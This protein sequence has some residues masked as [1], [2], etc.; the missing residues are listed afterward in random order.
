MSATAGSRAKPHRIRGRVIAGHMRV[1][2]AVCLWGSVSLYP[3]GGMAQTTQLGLSVRETLPPEEGTQDLPP[4]G[5]RPEDRAVEAEPLIPP[6]IPARMLA[7]RP[8]RRVVVIDQEWLGDSGPAVQRIGP[9]SM[10][11]RRMAGAQRGVGLAPGKATQGRIGR[12]KNALPTPPPA[13]DTD[14]DVTT[15]TD[16]D[17]DDTL[18]GTVWGLRPWLSHYGVTLDIQE[19][20]ELWGNLTGGVPPAGG[21]GAGTGPAFNGV[22][23]PTLTVDL[24]KLIGLKDGVFNVSALQIHGRSITQDRLFNYNPVSGIE[25]DRSTR[26][27]ELWYEQGFW[28]DKLD[29]KI[30][31]QDLDTE[32]VIST[33]GALYLNANF[34][35]PMGPS[36]NLYAGGPSWPLASPAVRV[37][38]RPATNLTLM[39][40][41][42]DDNPPGNSW[43]SFDAQNGGLGNV[44]DPTS[45]NTHNACGCRFNMGTGALLMGEIQYALNA[46]G[47]DAPEGRSAKAHGLP[48]VYK[49][50]GYYDTARFPDWRYTSTGQVLGAAYAQGQN[51][52][53]RM[54]RGNWLLYGIIDQMVWRPYRKSP[55]SL[56]VFARATGNGGDRNLISYGVDAGV[57]L[58]A[59][60]PNRENDTLGLGW[61][62]GRGS[63]GARMYYRTQGLRPPGTENHLEVTYQAEVKPWFVLQPDFQY[64]F[65]PS[66]GLE[67]SNWPGHKVADEVIF[68]LHSRLSF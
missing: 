18:L 31:Q 19:V 17:T 35:W 53:P 37:R 21:R 64:I 10:R 23:M 63:Y 16:S 67:N 24:E 2:G 9:A 60:F 11:M 1:L 56:G 5:V 7:P 48:G 8:D 29:I 54:V 45:Q 51:V 42:A 25:A 14:N 22:T 27:F 30:G 52:Q 59:P 49:L 68:G 62:L 58:K 15:D 40:A 41:A 12:G 32:F 3:L 4:E 6:E 13:P 38:Y 57:N 66:G 33:Y 47:H 61:G 39:F 50:G 36:A 34:S 43:N 26:L 44:A 65:N 28:D 55:T 46:E 20:D